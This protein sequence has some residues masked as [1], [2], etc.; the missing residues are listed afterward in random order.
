MTGLD[1]VISLLESVNENLTSHGEQVSSVSFEDLASKTEPKVTTKTYAGQP[2]SNAEITQAALAHAY[3]K[4]TINQLAANG[5][6]ESL[7]RALEKTLEYVEAH[8]Q[9]P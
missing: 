8:G 5:W 6:E 2:L 3:A 1:R 4:R 9:L 7:D